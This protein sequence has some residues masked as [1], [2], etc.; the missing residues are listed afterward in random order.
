MPFCCPPMMDALIGAY[1]KM[2]R[3]QGGAGRG[4]QSESDLDDF[5]HRAFGVPSR[6]DAPKYSRFNPPISLAKPRE[7]SSPAVAP[8]TRRNRP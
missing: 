4:E 7:T 5:G 3:M 2:R 8:P 1:W 6:R